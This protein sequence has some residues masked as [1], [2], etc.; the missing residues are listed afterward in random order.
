MGSFDI[1]FQFP[2]K[3]NVEELNSH[4]EQKFQNLGT[5]AFFEIKVVGFLSSSANPI[6]FISLIKLYC[7]SKI[8]TGQV[9]FS[10]CSDEL[11]VGTKLLCLQ[12]CLHGSNIPGCIFY[13]CWVWAAPLY[14]GPDFPWSLLQRLNC[15][16]KLDDCCNWETSSLKAFIFNILSVFSFW[17]IVNHSEPIF[18][19]SWQGNHQKL[20]ANGTVFQRHCGIAFYQFMVAREYGQNW[21]VWQR[22]QFGALFLIK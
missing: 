8:C 5:V 17:R 18:C 19:W 16:E 11:H 21:L 2:S 10:V 1:L 6:N 13:S 22:V 3:G 14:K 12:S 9:D 15:F 4:A 7:S 20:G